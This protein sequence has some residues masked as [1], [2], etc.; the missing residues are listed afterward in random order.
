MSKGVL[1]DQQLQFN[2]F[3]SPLVTSPCASS[4]RCSS[5][6]ITLPPPHRRSPGVHLL[7]S[8][9]GRGVWPRGA[10]PVR[11]APAS[12]FGHFRTLLRDQQTGTG[13]DL[14][15]SRRTAPRDPQTFTG[16]VTRHL[17]IGCPPLP[18]GT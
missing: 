17:L 3:S 1:E 8:L 11:E 4:F 2:W 16:E 14:S 13:E 18:L 6:P 15:V 12:D 9:C 7:L 5:Y 10:G